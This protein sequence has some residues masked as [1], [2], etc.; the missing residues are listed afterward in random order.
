MGISMIHKGKDEF[1][2]AFQCRRVRTNLLGHFDDAGREGQIC[3]GISMMQKD[4]DEFA[5]AFR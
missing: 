4:K 5:G 3:W 1:A 2:G